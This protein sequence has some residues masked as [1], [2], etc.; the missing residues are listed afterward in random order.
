[1]SAIAYPWTFE[2]YQISCKDKS[3]DTFIKYV[4]QIPDAFPGIWRHKI[5]NKI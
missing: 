3:E 1:M 5:T 2:I 4:G